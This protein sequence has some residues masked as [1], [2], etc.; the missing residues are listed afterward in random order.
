MAKKTLAG[1]EGILASKT[2]LRT[3]V[4]HS[5]AFGDITI[6]ELTFAQAKALRPY[7]GTD[8]FDPAYFIASVVNEDGSP[9]FRLPD[10]LDEMDGLSH[11]GISEIV[12][13]AVK[14]NHIAVE[15]EI[16]N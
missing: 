16:K 11:A 4:I 9:M 2:K 12:I 14:F 3:Q 15:T 1:R 8:Q 5:E 7:V 6:R 10:D 13:A